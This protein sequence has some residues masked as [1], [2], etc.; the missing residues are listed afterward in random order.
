MLRGLRYSA[1]LALACAGGKETTPEDHPF[2]DAQGR[3]CRATLEKTSP[4]SPSVRESVS[5]EGQ[6]K[7]CSSGSAPCFELSIDREAQG[8]MNCPAC[9]KGS[10]VS[11]VSKECSAIVCE[12]DEDCIFG[13]ARCLDGVCLCPEGSCE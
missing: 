1:L 8:V 2:S 11:F 3:S 9:C 7:E 12:A 6:T 13:K 10:A 5:C 4:S